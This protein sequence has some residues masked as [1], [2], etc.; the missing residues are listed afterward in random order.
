MMTTTLTLIIPTYNLGSYFA[1]MLGALQRQTRPFDLWLVDDGSMDETAS[2]AEAFTRGIPNFHYFAFSRHQGV[3]TARN[4]GLARA[5]TAAV[6]F[7]DGDDLIADDFVQVLATAMS[8]AV[9]AVA[10]GYRWF[11]T[12]V[13]AKGE[14]RLD[15][16]AMFEQV[17]HHG[18][19]IGGY[20]WNKAFRR[21]AITAANLQ[22]DPTLQLAEDYWFTA[23]FVARTP[24]PY[25]YLPAVRYTKRNRPNSTIHRAGFQARA[26][27][28]AVFERIRQLRA[29][30]AR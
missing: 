17:S 5:T 11:R 16:A 15:Q 20:V 9:S 24:G 1:G 8:P 12:P 7:I 27:E 13:V 18:T 4:Y 19:A 2:Q 3:S 21:A 23:S 10:V 29:G 14:Q 28:D 25:V 6:A 30:L 22:F 26:Q